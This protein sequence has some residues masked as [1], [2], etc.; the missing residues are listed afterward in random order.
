MIEDEAG[1]VCALIARWQELYGSRPVRVLI[2]R[3]MRL[4]DR[5]PDLE[6]FMAAR[7]YPVIDGFVCEEA[8]WKRT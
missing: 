4:L 3:R 2:G 5:D 1:E 8:R 7:G 6:A